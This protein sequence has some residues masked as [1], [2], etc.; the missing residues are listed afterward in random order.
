MKG[1][2]AKVSGGEA[3]RLTAELDPKAKRERPALKTGAAH[4]KTKRH[5]SGAA[6]ETKKW[7]S[8]CRRS[9][10]QR[11]NPNGETVEKDEALELM[12]TCIKRNMKGLTRFIRQPS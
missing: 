8:I 6:L 12:V 5:G 1:L 10:A 7:R 11:Q 3:V 2:T 4:A 9:P